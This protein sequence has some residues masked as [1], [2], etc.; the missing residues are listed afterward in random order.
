[1]TVSQLLPLL[2]DH[3]AAFVHSLSLKTLVLSILMNSF[4][5]ESMF[6]LNID[7]TEDWSHPSPY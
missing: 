2:L 3:S 6:Y 7:S 4:T 5:K 1:M